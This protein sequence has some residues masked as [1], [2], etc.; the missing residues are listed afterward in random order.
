MSKSKYTE[1]YKRSVADYYENND[2]SY[3][4]VGEKFNVN[5]TLVRNWHLKYSAKTTVSGLASLSDILGDADDSADVY[6]LVDDTATEYRA[7]P[8]NKV[9]ASEEMMLASV[10][11][12]TGQSISREKLQELVE[13]YENGELEDENQELFDAAMFACSSLARA[14]FALDPDDDD[15]EID[16]SVSF[17]TND[18]GSINAEIRPS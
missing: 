10:K 11:E 16:Y 4:A 2:V 8:R 7:D 15:E 5:P 12:E 3:K 13:S 6:E 14:C 1:E 18:D 9:F 17:I